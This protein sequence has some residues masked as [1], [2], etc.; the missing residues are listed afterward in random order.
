VAALNAL[1]EDGSVSFKTVN[2]AIKKYGIDP[3]KNN[4]LMS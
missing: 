1:M 3:N 2:A 4:P